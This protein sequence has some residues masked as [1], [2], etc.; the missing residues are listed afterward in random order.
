VSEK[1]SGHY[2]AK[3]QVCCFALA[4]NRKSGRY[5][6]GSK[7]KR[8]PIYV[9]RGEELASYGFGEDHPFGQDRHAAFHDELALAGLDSAIEYRLPRRASVDELALFH[10]PNYIDFISK[11]SHEGSGYLDGGD[12]PAIAGIFNME[13]DTMRIASAN[14]ETARTI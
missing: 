11:K 13:R 5:V 14:G 12:T 2:S 6:S 8:P 9:Y 1:Y 10:T 3:Y 7:T 4:I